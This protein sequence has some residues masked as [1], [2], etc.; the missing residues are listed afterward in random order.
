M[1]L[2]RDFEVSAGGGV[3][4]SNADAGTFIM[5]SAASNCLLLSLSREHLRSLLI[6]FDSVVAR[7]LAA[8][9]PA[10]RLLKGYLC[11][12]DELP[13]LPAELEH[14]LVAHVYDIVA[15]VLGATGEVVDIARGRGLRAARLRAATTYVLR[16][17]CSQ[18][19]SAATVAAQLGV[20]PRYVHMLFETEEESFTELVLNRRLERS[21]RML[22]D[23]RFNRLTISA[24]ALDAGFA[25]LSHFNR[26]FRR[27]FGATPSQ[28]R[29][30]A[31]HDGS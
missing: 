11:I 25:D 30:Q 26:S 18:D 16:N 29:K 19:L 31:R 17:L 7:P 1:H 27:R 2:G 22:I 9:T 8:D 10:F 28:V 14:S 5:P 20:T 3:L 4:S 23:S 6:D 13:S 12:F 15:T 24:I 21:H